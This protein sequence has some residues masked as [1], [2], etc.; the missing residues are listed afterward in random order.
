VEFTASNA[1]IASADSVKTAAPPIVAPNAT[2]AKILEQWQGSLVELWTPTTHA[3]GFVVDASG[4]V[5]TNQRVVNGVTSVEVQLTPALKVTGTVLTAEPGRD[6][7]II[8]ID[9][10]ALAGLT[11]V[12]LTCAS[13]PP[14]PEK[15]QQVFA[16]GAPMRQ[17]R[18]IEAGTLGR[19]GPH[20]L[21]SDLDFEPGSVGGPV[22]NG[23]GVVLGLTSVVDGSDE[24]RPDYRVIR[25]GDICTVI[26]SA[27]KAMSGTQPP[28]G[29]P[30]PVEP[31]RAFPGDALQSAAKARAGGFTPYQTSSEFEAAFITPVW[32]YAARNRTRPTSLPERT[33][34]TRVADPEAVRRQEGLF[35]FGRWSDYV[36]GYPPVL[37]VRVTPRLKEGF[38]TMI[39]RGAAQTQGVALP[40]M[41]HFTSGFARLQA[42]CGDKEV[43]PI[44]AFRLEREV[45]GTTTLSEGLY[46]FAPD[47]LAPTC[48]PAKLVLYSQKSPNDGDTLVIDSKLLDQTLQDFAPYRDAR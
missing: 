31:A 12:P 38:W 4:L 27:A 35:D 43:I 40:A 17:A 10:A 9:P 37:L 25:T 39:A 15:G 6:V 45:T 29:A 41:K 48:A 28:S 20:A 5:A 33:M 14:S 46:V 36:Q 22:L 47:A 34:R 11:P 26:A 21:E 44:H 1:E 42:F 7:A 13:T 19:I 3:S 8:R 30:L 32:V 24:R 2:A 16:L 18:A 23:D